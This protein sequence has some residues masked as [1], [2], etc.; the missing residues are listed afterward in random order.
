[1][2]NDNILLEVV[3]I[4]KTVESA[5]LTE[6]ARCRKDGD[7]PS[8]EV[9]IDAEHQ[10]FIAANELLFKRHSLPNPFIVGDKDEF[11]CRAAYIDQETENII[12]KGEG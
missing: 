8:P 5:M 1:M 12:K 2:T 7:D 11:E 10:L 4:C 6:F 3:R 9:M